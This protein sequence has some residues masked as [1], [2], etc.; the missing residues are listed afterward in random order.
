MDNK[1]KADGE[2]PEEPECEDGRRDEDGRMLRKTVE[3][4]KTLQRTEEKRN[5]RR[6][7]MQLNRREVK[8]NEEEIEC[9]T[10]GEAPFDEQGGDLDLEQVRQGRE[11]EM[12]CY[13]QD[14]W[15]VRAWFLARS[16]VE[17]RQGSDLDEMDRPSEDGRRRS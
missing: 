7:C 2:H 10:E 17:S 15:D 13:C 12:N 1:R 6:H 14:A 4:L 5:L 8:V 9:R 3:Y 11:E 16:D